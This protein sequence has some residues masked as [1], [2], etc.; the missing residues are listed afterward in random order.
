VPRNACSWQL[1]KA[2]VRARAAKMSS[3]ARTLPEGVL[4]DSYALNASVHSKRHILPPEQGFGDRQSFFML[5]VFKC[6]PGLLVDDQA[7]LFRR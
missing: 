2:D 4:I 6:F 5:Y 1:K 3:H 7:N